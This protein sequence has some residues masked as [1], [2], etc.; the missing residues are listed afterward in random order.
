MQILLIGA[1]SVTSRLNLVLTEH[2]HSIAA[3]MATFTPQHLDLFDFKGIVAVSPEASI[4]TDSLRQAAE[5]GKMIFVVAGVEDGLASWANGVGVPAFAFPLSEVETNKLLTEISR[6]DSGNRAA[7]EQ[8]RRAVLGSDMSA[9][10][11]SGMNVR[12]IAITSPKGGTGKTTM[13]VN[14]AVAF[15]LSGI[16]TYLIDA[17]A[18]AGS[19]QYHLRLQKVKSTLMGVLRRAIGQSSGTMGKIASGANYL[20]AFTTLDALPT[21]KVLPGLVTDDLGDCV[22]Q[23]EERV[24]DVLQGLYE[25]GVSTGGVVIVDVGINPAHVVHRSALRLAEGIAI[26]VK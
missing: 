24:A 25:A 17:D 23:N 20:D 6:A 7:E 11:Q 1:G 2:K 8:Y 21:L 4:S 5:R 9:R 15:A 13:S 12:K 22:L 3:Q 19:L 14:L 16:T 18:N 10:I 26:V